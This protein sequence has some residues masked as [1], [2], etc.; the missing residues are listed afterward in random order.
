MRNSVSAEAY[1]IY[2]KQEDFKAKVI[3]KN[4]ESKE[5]IRDKLN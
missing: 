3:L 1:G 2:N 4:V 5:R